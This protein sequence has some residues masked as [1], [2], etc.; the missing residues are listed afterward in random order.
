MR[1]HQGIEHQSGGVSEIDVDFDAIRDSD[2]GDF[3]ELGGGA[4]EI[5]VAFING[6]LPVVPG[7]GTLTAGGSAT[8]D[9]QMLVWHPYWAFD[10]DLG[11]FGVAYELISD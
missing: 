7:L 10:L 1:N 9:S 3:F 6:H 11:S 2:G 4:L 5:D 8:A